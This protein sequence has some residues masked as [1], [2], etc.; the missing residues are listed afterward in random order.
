MPVRRLSAT[1]SRAVWPSKET[2]AGAVS[3]S[4][5]LWDAG[6]G[7]AARRDE[8]GARI[9]SV[10]LRT[11]S[12]LREP[13]ATSRRFTTSAQ[14]WP[15]MLATASSTSFRSSVTTSSTTGAQ[16]RRLEQCSIPWPSPSRA[17]GCGPSYRPRDRPE[18]WAPATTLRSA[19]AARL[20][21]R[22]RWSVRP[23]WRTASGAIRAPNETSLK[24]LSRVWRNFLADCVS[25][26]G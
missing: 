17:C 21:R 19:T 15:L 9:G 22:R 24:V 4:R 23:C 5:V 14:N 25:S 7:R 6:G 13:R 8:P 1:M 16:A 11:L 2:T 20:S 18:L 12:A 26:R 10:T 3:R